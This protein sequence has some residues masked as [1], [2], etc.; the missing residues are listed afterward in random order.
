[1]VNYGGVRFASALSTK[2]AW[3]EAAE[4]LAGQ[5]QSQL[6]GASCDLLLLFLHPHYREQSRE[7][8]EQLRV[9]VGAQHLVG[10]TGASV[11]GEAQEVEDR[12]SVAALAAQWPGVTTTPFHLTQ[13]E[14]EAA[15]GP[16][17]WHF[18]LEVEPKQNPNLLLL[19]D[20]FSI[21]IIELVKNLSEAYPGAPIVGGL[22]SGSQQP[23]ETRLILDE[24][25]F[26][27]GAVGVA[28]TGP[29]RLHTIVS[30]GC[31]PIGEPMVVTRADK[32]VVFEIGGRAPME[33]LRDLHPHLSA[34][35][36]QLAQ[37]SLLLGRVINEYQE[38]FGRGDF[39]IRNLIGH[40]P[41]TG[42]IAVGDWM[43]TGQTVQF[44]VRDGQ[45]AE[46]ELNALLDQ[47]RQKL[48]SRLPA[49]AVLFSCL[50]RGERMYGV[51]HHDIRAL[52]EK[53][54]PI[55]T[56]GFFCNGEIGPVGDQSYV[57]GFTSVFGLFCS[58]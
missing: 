45:T 20:P 41:K 29:V 7:L 37:T 24:E 11:I 35:D 34:R 18:Q 8:A 32:N 42:A 6:R 28:L 56:A 33:V 30:Q 27:D 15:T 3:S 19:A 10:C 17:Y 26:D 38:S 25:V 36:Q 49:G 55:P 53:F 2:K 21:R 48:G 1:L 5:V 9:S 39:L 44:Q 47:H 51:P 4:D 50:G 58:A 31:K 43:R 12:P 40:D 16:G 54:G 23:G 13:Q 22:A 14:I 52:H 57:H 46:E